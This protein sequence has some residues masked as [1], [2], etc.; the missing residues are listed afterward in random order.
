[1][2]APAHHSAMRHVITARKEIGVRTVF[3][4][5]GPLTNPAAAPNQIMGVFEQAWIPPLLEVSKELGSNHVLIVSA[6][7]GLDEISIAA[8]TQVGE[9]KDGEMFSY[10]VS[11]EDFGIERYDNFAEL[12]IDSVEASLV[13]LKQAL[14]YENKA[15]GDIVALNAGAAI[16][17]ANLSVDLAAGV[18]QAKEILSSGAALEKLSELVDFSQS[19]AN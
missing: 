8:T 1:M 19:V 10:S 18:E 12:Q 7:D 3:N 5:L 9:L 16:Y 2:F 15:A 6:D 13:M 17:V 4:L 11:P 14:T